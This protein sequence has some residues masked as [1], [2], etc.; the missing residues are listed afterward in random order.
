VDRSVLPVKLFVG[1]LSNQKR[2]FLEAEA[3]LKK[4]F[5]AIDFSSNFIKFDLTDYYEKEMGKGLLR[6]FISFKK[7]IDPGKLAV[8]KVYT[9]KIEQSLAKKNGSRNINLD[10]G[11][12]TESSLLLAT[13]KNFQHRIYLSMGI[14]AE[15]TLRYCKGTFLPNEWTY[16]DYKTKEYN[17]IFLNIRNTYRRQLKKWNEQKNTGV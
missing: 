10:P 14:F 17:E 2:F 15:V 3:Q 7:I 12:I 11:Y 8:I 13:T 9:N 1:M 6:K 5:G 4:K 16:R